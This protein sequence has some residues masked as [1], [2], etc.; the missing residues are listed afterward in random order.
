MGSFHPGVTQFVY[1]DGSVHNIADSVELEVYKDVATV[2][3][4]EVSKSPL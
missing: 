2:N 1:I 4:E 3:G